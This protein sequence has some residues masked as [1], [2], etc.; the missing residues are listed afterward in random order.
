MLIEIFI[1]GT[2]LLT[3]PVLILRIC[4]LNLFSGWGSDYFSAS[5]EL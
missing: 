5:L 4:E 3:V 1:N 2:D